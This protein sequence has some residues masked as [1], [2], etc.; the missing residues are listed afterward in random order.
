[1]QGIAVLSVILCC[2]CT[3]GDRWRVLLRGDMD[4]YIHAVAVNVRK[5]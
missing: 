5:I 4:D 3:V 2:P 1:M